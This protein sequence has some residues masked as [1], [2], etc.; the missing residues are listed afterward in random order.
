MLSY[1]QKDFPA[2]MA[3]FQRVLETIP[4]DGATA[5]YLDACMKKS[6]P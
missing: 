4:D 3:S 1:Y 6:R 2:A 5:F